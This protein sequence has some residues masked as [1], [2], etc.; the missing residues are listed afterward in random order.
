MVAAG[1]WTAFDRCRTGSALDCARR[2]SILVG[3]AAAGAL[4]L[5]PA[6]ART[7]VPGDGS[8]TTPAPTARWLDRIR[9]AARNVS[10]QGTMTYSAGGAVSSSRVAHYCNGRDRYE[11][12]EGLD[13]RIRQQ[14]RVNDQ[15]VTLWPAARLAVIEQHEATSDF[16]A[17]PPAVPGTLD[18]YELRPVGTERV[19]GLLADVLLLAPRDQRRFAQRQW[20]HRDS[21]LMLRLDVLAAHG[22]V[23]ETSAFTDV[24]LDPKAELES[25]RGPIKRLEGWKVVRPKVVKTR[26]EDEGWELSHPVPGFEPVECLR[27]PLDSNGAESSPA[28]QVLQTVFSDGLAQVSV[29]VE[30]YDAQRHKP[31]RSALGAT[32]TLMSRRG[33]WWLTV[34]GEVPMSTVQRF[35]SALQR[36]H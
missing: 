13:G 14:Y 17:L 2:R 15:V 29:F 25:V 36:R 18:H 30:P 7:P 16:P 19:S 8:P 9:D 24:V 23:L 22:D 12:V 1:H 4:A 35:E 32:H 27:R 21:G 20:A 26:L 5:R 33:E 3:L 10:Y 6:I 31:V 34:M 11:R 28:V